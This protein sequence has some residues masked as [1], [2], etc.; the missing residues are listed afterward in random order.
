MRKCAWCTKFPTL[1]RKRIGR[2]MLE[3]GNCADKEKILG[4]V[5]KD[6]WK[7][8]LRRRSGASL[9]TMKITFCR[10]VRSFRA[11]EIVWTST[12]GTMKT[13]RP[14]SSPVVYI[15]ASP[16]HLTCLMVS[17]NISCLMK[18]LFWGNISSSELCRCSIRMGSSMVTIGVL[19]WAVIWTG[20]GRSQ[21]D[22]YTR[23]YFTPSSSS[24]TCI[25]NAR[26]SC[27][28][29]FMVIP[30][31]TMPFSTVVHTKI[32]SRRAV[33]KTP[34]SESSLFCVARETNYSASEI[35][36]STLKNARN[37]PL[38]WLCGEKWTSWMLSP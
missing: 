5:S 35:A 8:L 6:S 16:K 18:L 37:L 29:I 30:A 12:W 24:G 7:L 20:N 32:T 26:S 14:S 4:A 28:V 19:F 2:S 22:F 27:T 10:P 23:P 31:K 17:S 13:R 3:R 15:L 21:T 25:R 34:S 38:G 11:L 1:S 9:S 36:N 33:S